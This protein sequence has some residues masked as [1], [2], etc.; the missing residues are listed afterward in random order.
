MACEEV[1]LICRRCSLGR[2]VPVIGAWVQFTKLPNG[3]VS[4]TRLTQRAVAH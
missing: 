1:E 4:E 3:R 2:I